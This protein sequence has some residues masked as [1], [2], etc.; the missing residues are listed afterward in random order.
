[1]MELPVVNLVKLILRIHYIKSLETKKS[2]HTMQLGAF[3]VEE[4]TLLIRFLLNV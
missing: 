3:M 4:I 2:G 1:M